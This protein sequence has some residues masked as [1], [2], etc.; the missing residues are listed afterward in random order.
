MAD[1][2][3]EE[4]DEGKPKSSL[5]ISILVSAVLGFVCGGLGFFVTSLLAGGDASADPVEL[6][7]ETP[8]FIPFGDVIVNLGD[9]RMSRYLSVGISLQIY[10][11]DEEQVTKDVELQSPVLQDWLNQ[12]LSGLQLEDVRGGAS[13]NRIRR[14]ILNRFNELLAPDGTDIVQEVL[15]TKFTVQ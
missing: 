6:E 9:P 12:Y 14:D 1:D 11:K 8:A 4:K 3:A 13:Q 10:Q 5:L 15:F 7:D 2:K